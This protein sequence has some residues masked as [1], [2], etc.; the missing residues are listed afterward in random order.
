MDYQTPVDI[1]K[2]PCA[3]AGMGANLAGLAH[4]AL[5]L[6]ELQVQL[7]SVDLRDAK[8]GAGPALALLVVGAVL[9]LGSIPV[10]LIAGAASLIEYADWSSPAAHG[11]MGAAAVALAVLLLRIGWN[12][13]VRALGTVQ[14]SRSE[15]TETLQWL[16]NSLREGSRSAK[17]RTRSNAAL[18][19]LS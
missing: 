14:R 6:A 4:D 3:R 17:D 10:L 13:T 5:S 12:R 8:R 1:D 11:V 16:K 15:F 2:Q 7:L 18:N 19:R 9:A